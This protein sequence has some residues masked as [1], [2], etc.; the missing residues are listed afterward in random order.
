MGV[1]VGLYK[2]NNKI[3]HIFFMGVR[4]GLYKKN[5]KIKHIEEK[6]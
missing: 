1:R 3:K 4:I 5:N 6:I 2:K